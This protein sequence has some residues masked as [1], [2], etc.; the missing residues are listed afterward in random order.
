MTNVTR[1][2][3]FLGVFFFALICAVTL[4]FCGGETFGTPDF[5]WMIGIGMVFGVIAGVLTATFPF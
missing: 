2:L 1:V 5:A 4:A 3:I